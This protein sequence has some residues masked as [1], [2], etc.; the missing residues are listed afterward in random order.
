MNLNQLHNFR[1][2]KRLMQL[3]F[4][5]PLLTTS[6]AHLISLGLGTVYVGSIYLSKNAR[7]RFNTR[8]RLKRTPDRD[9]NGN[10]N[11][12]KV[13]ERERQRNERWRDDPDVIRAR[14]V[15]V[16]VATVV[17]IFCVLAVLWSN[18]GGTLRVCFTS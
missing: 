15:A 4:P 9:G 6:S 18:V 13:R 12:G 16:S 11:A 1:P 3:L 5:K 2:F 8:T 17:C 7:L 14:L 10:G